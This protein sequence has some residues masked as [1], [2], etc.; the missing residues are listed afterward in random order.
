MRLTQADRLCVPVPLYQCFGMVLGNPACLTHAAA[1]VYPKDG[2]D[3]FTVLET[4]QAE[5]CT[6]L[7]GVPT[8]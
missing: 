7:H 4:V 1:I 2:F 5:R 3:S 6:G 8:F